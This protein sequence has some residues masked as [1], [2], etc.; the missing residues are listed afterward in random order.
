MSA[1]VDLEEVDSGWLFVFSGADCANLMDHVALDE[2][3]VMVSVSQSGGLFDVFVVG[4]QSGRV[5]RDFANEKASV[6]AV[7]EEAR[8]THVFEGGPGEM[9]RLA[10]RIYKMVHF[11]KKLTVA[12]SLC[13]VS[14]P[15]VYDRDHFAQGYGRVRIRC[16][17]AR[18]ELCVY[19]G[20]SAQALAWRDGGW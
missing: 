18:A 2:G 9:G 5:C 15:S 14:G 4:W 6:S 1:H 12:R 8:R 17:M 19:H 7:W 11:L 13:R 10:V 3:F 20:S 16:Q